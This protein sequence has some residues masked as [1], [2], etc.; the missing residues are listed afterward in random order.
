MKYAKYIPELI[1]AF[2]ENE[3]ERVKGMIAWSLGRIGGEKSKIALERIKS[4]S[5]GLVK[6]EIELAL[7]IVA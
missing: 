3:D 6:K 5:N 7:S 2:E 1:K 4:N